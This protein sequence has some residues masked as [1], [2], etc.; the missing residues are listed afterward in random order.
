[1]LSDSYNG[2]QALDDEEDEEDSE[3]ED[4]PTISCT[5]IEHL[6]IDDLVDLSTPKPLAQFM[7][8]PVPNNST[9]KHAPFT[10]TIKVVW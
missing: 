9:T 8:S 4:S 2:A 5:S 3:D 6:Q 7:E 10:N 1:M